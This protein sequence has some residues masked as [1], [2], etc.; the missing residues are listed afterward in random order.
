MAE[1]L[2]FFPSKGE[3]SIPEDIGY[4]VNKSTV[5]WLQ[6]VIVLF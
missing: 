1:H 2:P 3:K 4:R 6:M 5:Y